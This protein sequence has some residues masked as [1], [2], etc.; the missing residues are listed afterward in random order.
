MPSMIIILFLL[1]VTVLLFVGRLADIIHNKYRERKLSSL[2]T[3]ATSA[4]I[5]TT[6]S[7]AA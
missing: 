2:S 3:A 5:D 7:E 4:E 6:K 1:G